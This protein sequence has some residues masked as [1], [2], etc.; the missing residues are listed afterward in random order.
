MLLRLLWLSFFWRQQGQLWTTFIISSIFHS[1][2]ARNLIRVYWLRRAKGSCYSWFL[3]RSELARNTCCLQLF[4][5][6]LI[7]HSEPA[8]NFILVYPCNWLRRAKGSWFL[9]VL[10]L[11]KT[12]SCYCVPQNFVPLKPRRLLLF[13]SPKTV[14][15]K[16]VSAESASLKIAFISLKVI[17]LSPMRFAFKQNDF[18]RFIP[19]IFLTLTRWFLSVVEGQGGNQGIA[20]GDG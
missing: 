12:F 2:P 15:K 14:N 5:L 4:L 16:S 8:R 17:N 13:L 18:L 6:S 19:P 11:R 3:F 9:P 1:E 7:L 20:K 10:S